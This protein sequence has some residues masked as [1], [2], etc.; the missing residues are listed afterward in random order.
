MEQAGNEQGRTGTRIAKGPDVKG[1]RS[2]RNQIV[3]VAGRHGTS[4]HRNQVGKGPGREGTRS[5]REQVVK[6]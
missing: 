5:F 3:T 4:S 6:E 2:F 1:T